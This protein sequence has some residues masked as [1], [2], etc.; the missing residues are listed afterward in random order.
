MEA[1]L[2]EARYEVSRELEEQAEQKS[3]GSCPTMP[4]LMKQYIVGYQLAWTLGSLLLFAEVFAHLAHVPPPVVSLLDPRLA[5]N[6]VLVGIPSAV[7][8]SRLER[9]RSDAS[10]A[11]SPSGS[12]AA[13][14][15]RRQIPAGVTYVPARLTQFATPTLQ[16]VFLPVRPF[17]PFFA[18]TSGKQVIEQQPAMFAASLVG[19]TLV[20]SAWTHGLLQASWGAFLDDAALRLVGAGGLA[21]GDLGGAGDVSGGAAAFG[22]DVMGALAGSEAI[23]YQ[24]PLLALSHFVSAAAPLAA[25]TVAVA[26]AALSEGALCRAL[27]PMAT[28]RQAEAEAEAVASLCRRAPTLWALEAPP[29]AVRRRVAALRS[30]ASRWAEERSEAERRSRI[31]RVGR[32]AV[33]TAAFGASGGSLVAPVLASLGIISGAASPLG[34]DPPK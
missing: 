33:A 20:G 14:A 32:A 21:A 27:Q 8:V 6:G 1:T 17:Y 24:Y 11:A 16:L 19:G 13:L 30:E 28:R 7:I 3:S 18:E 4:S 31:A 23:I 9:W 29:D 5:L 26:V 2:A 34:A 15:D 25:A 12:S 22:A 10:S